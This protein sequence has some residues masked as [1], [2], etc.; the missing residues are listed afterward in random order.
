MSK[1]GDLFQKI[2]DRI[3][4]AIETGNHGKWQKPWTTVIG[5]AGESFNPSKGH[6]GYHGFNE[7]VL[8]FTTAVEGYPSNVWATYKQWQTL[9]GQVQKGEEGTVLVKWGKTYRCATCPSKGSRP[10][11]KKDHD[12]SS[13]MWASPFKVFNLGQQE[14]FDLELPDLGDAPA[15]LDRVE[16]M[17]AGTGAEIRHAASNQAYFHKGRDQITLP[18]VEQFDS[19]QSYYGTALHELTHWSGHKDRLDRKVGRM[20]GDAEYAA[21]ELVAELG[22]TF[23]AAKFGVEVEPHP[24]HADYLA[25]WVKGMKDHPKALYSAAK[26]AQ[27]STDF[28]IDLADEEKKEEEAA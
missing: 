7:L 8:M 5:A 12:V 2:T 24:E 20:F 11:Q 26:M 27:T 13:S 22:S 18:L 1:T 3:V 6:K 15:R 14:G 23:L 19:T 25:S 4:E 16:K 28:L 9:G 17:I 21:E 10:C